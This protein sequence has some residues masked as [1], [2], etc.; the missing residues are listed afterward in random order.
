MTMILVKKCDLTEI[1]RQNRQAVKFR[2]FHKFREN[3]FSTNKSKQFGLTKIRF[4]MYRSKVSFHG[5][6]E[7]YDNCQ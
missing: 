5:N 2:N 4:I 3:K 6:F 1:L 7:K